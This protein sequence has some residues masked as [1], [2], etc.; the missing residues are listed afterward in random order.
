MIQIYAI[1]P[2]NASIFTYILLKTPYFAPKKFTRASFLSA[3]VIFAQPPTY[4][5]GHSIYVR[6][7]LLA[8]PHLIL[9]EDSLFANP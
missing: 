7:Y 9:K 4:L 5:R 1:I 8:R 6:P 2:Y 3:L